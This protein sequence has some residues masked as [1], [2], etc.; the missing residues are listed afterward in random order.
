MR[1]GAVLSWSPFLFPCLYSPECLEVVFSEL[2]LETVRK[3][4]EQ[5]SEPGF[6]RYTRYEKG[7][8][9]PSRGSAGRYALDASEAF[10]TVSRVR[11]LGSPCSPGPSPSCPYSPSCL[12]V[13]SHAACV[14]NLPRPNRPTSDETG[15]RA[16]RERLRGSRGATRIEKKG[17][18]GA[19]RCRK[20]DRRRVAV[21]P[22]EG[23]R[24]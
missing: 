23:W 8:E 22:W 12:E 17:E 2:P 24:K 14:S 6:G 7:R 18:R 9:A 21:S 3:G 19:P 13:A 20:P 5:R 15:R 10:R 11:V 16:A 4:F 1:T